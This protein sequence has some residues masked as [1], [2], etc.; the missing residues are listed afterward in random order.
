MAAT[1]M[2]NAPLPLSHGYPLRVVLPGIAGARWTKWLDR[3]HVQPHESGNFY[4]Q[5]DY[6]ILPPH[7]DTKAL[8]EAHWP[9]VP[10]IQGLPI[11]SIIAYP[12]ANSVLPST[13]PIKVGGY[14]LPQADDGP[15]VAVDVSTDQG[16]SWHPATITT[17]TE[18]A[19]KY[20]WAWAIWKYTLTNEQARALSRDTKIWSRARD[21]GGNVQD[22]EIR[23]NFRGVAYNAYGETGGLTVEGARTDARL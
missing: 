8:A 2:N 13:S 3:I 14:A 1:Q 22:G 20:K 11:N 10:A 18:P 5:K 4:M 23:W 7:I 9:L 12:A 16:R 21:R 17:P 19:E 15:V 6:K